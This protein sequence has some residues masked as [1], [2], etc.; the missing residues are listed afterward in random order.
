MTIGS[1]A[2]WGCDIVEVCSIIVNN[3]VMIKIEH[4]K[5]VENVH[6]DSIEFI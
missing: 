6:I 2:I 4:S 3:F 5:K 1:K